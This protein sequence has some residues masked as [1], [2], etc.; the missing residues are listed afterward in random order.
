MKTRFYH[1][2]L[3]TILQHKSVIYAKDGYAINNILDIALHKKYKK[4][5]EIQYINRFK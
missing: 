5:I 4:G 3:T 2:V 1:L